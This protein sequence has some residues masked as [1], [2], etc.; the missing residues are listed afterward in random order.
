MLARRAGE[1][2]PDEYFFDDC[3]LC[4]HARESGGHIVFDA[5]EDADTDDD[6][7]DAPPNTAAR[8][9]ERLQPSVEFDQAMQEL[10]VRATAFDDAAK[11]RVPE[12]LADRIGF[13]VLIL[14]DTIMSAI[15]DHETSRTV[16]PVEQQIGRAFTTIAAARAEA[17]ELEVEAR[18]LEGAL[19]RLV[20]AWRGL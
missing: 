12:W 9:D 3:P 5:G 11:N 14:H 1:F 13:D 16:E 8:S 15:W 4:Q 2:D 18:Q 19:R 7:A 10:A 6:A 17:P 20:A